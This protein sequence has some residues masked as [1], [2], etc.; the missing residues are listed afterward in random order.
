[1]ILILFRECNNQLNDN[2]YKINNDNTKIN[3]FFENIKI[4]AQSTIQ[5]DNNVNYFYLPKLINQLLKIGKEFP[6]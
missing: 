4:T 3:E 1:M 6:L 2:V 5:E